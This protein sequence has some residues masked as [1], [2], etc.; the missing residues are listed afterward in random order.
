MLEGG[1]NASAR[2]KTGC[3]AKNSTLG[4]LRHVL[5]MGEFFPGPT[6]DVKRCGFGYRQV[7][8]VLIYPVSARRQFSA[9]KPN[10][11]VLNDPQGL[12]H[13]AFPYQAQHPSD[14]CFDIRHILMP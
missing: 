8:P 13:G 9:P 6:R 7:Q 10:P 14:C 11:V 4:T 1:R 3:R 5:F 12:G 2:E